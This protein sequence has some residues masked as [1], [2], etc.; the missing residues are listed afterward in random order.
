MEEKVTDLSQ[1]KEIA[2]DN[3]EFLKEIFEIFVTQT[4]EYIE[5]LQ[6]GLNTKDFELMRNT[7]HKMYTSLGTLGIRSLISTVK[8]LENDCQNKTGFE[9]M[10]SKIA[11]ITTTCNKAIAELEEELKEL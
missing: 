5:A 9:E 2:G 3:P 6:K 8:G 1:I 7:A 10:P 11:L 4:P